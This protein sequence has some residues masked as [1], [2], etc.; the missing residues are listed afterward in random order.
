MF[1]LFQHI[2]AVTPREAMSSVVT[3]HAVL[4]DVRT[5][6]EYQ[7]GHAAGARH[8][9][10]ENVGEYVEELKQKKEVYVIC[11]SGGRSAEAV[12]F[13]C[14][15]GINAINITGGTTLWKLDGLAME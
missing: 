14:K 3:A 4:I 6:R 8:I 1:H 11:Q 7:S 13:L 2:P 9:P 12:L 10:L 15:Q 5:A